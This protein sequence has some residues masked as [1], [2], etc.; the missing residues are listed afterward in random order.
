MG[1]WLTRMRR[2]TLDVMGIRA[3]DQ[4]IEASLTNGI[5]TISPRA[6]YTSIL[7][8]SIGQYLTDESAAGQA[9]YNEE[10]HS[11]FDNRVRFLVF[12]A[13]VVDQKASRRGVLGLDFFVRRS[14]GPQF[15]PE[16]S[17][18]RQGQ[19]RS[20]RHLFRARQRDWPCRES[21]D[22]ERHHLWAY[23]SGYADLRGAQ[24]GAR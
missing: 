13:T 9:I 12:A 23:S 2:K 21:P 15:R 11:I 18:A 19:L 14:C 24:E 17:D 16:R 22:R 10:K 1:S 6:R 4:N 5:T 20:L 8:W 7:A 3:L